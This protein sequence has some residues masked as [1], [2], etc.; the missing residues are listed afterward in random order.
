MTICSL[1]ELEESSLRDLLRKKSPTFILGESNSCFFDV[2]ERFEDCPEGLA[3]F[4]Q[5]DWVNLCECYNYQLLE[6]WENNR[7]DI[8]EMFE[9]FKQAFGYASTLE[10][11]ENCIVEDPEDM[12]TAMVNCAMTY[13]AQTLYDV[14][15]E[16]L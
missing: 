6:R 9:E 5:S 15:E 7:D 8:V 10:A 2:I 11:L 13:A 14:L 1:Q 12:A 3:D 16:E 4:Q